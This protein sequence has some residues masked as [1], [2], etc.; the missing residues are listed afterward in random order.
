M[1]RSF[2]TLQVQY[3]DGALKLTPDEK[4]VELFLMLNRN[5]EC[6]GAQ[7]VHPDTIKEYTGL[8]QADVEKALAGLEKKNR[9]GRCPVNWIIVLGKWEHQQRKTG[10]AETALQNSLET[11]PT[12]LQDLLTFYLENH[13]KVQEDNKTTTRPQVLEGTLLGSREKGVVNREQGVDSANAATPQKDIKT[14][15]DQKYID[16]TTKILPDVKGNHIGKQADALRLLC[17]EYGDDEVFAVLTWMRSDTEARDKWK[18]WSAVFHSIT[19][20]RENGCQKYRNAR[21]QFRAKQQ[22]NDKPLHEYE[23]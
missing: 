4:L 23:M 14:S 17:K 13:S 16:F 12:Q 22:A 1:A 19:R 11:A 20:L 7:Q 21:A 9:I 8:K 3:W 2:Q 10:Q 15:V 5:C 18:G 6:S